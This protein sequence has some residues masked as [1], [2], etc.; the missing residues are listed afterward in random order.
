MSWLDILIAIVLGLGTFAG[1][2]RGLIGE[3]SGIVALGA[4]VVAAFNYPGTFDPWVAG[5]THLGSGSA[6]VVGMFCFGLIAYA[7]ILVV[8]SVLS[9]IAKLPILGLLN[10]AGGARDRLVQVA[11][12]SLGRAVRRALL[13]PLARSSRRTP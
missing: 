13:P 10:A 8:G 5:R 1:F 7:I 6:H 9:G 12:L 2:R 11:A 4:A 3:L